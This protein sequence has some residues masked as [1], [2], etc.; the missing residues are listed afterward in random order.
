MRKS[1]GLIRM[2]LVTSNVRNVVFIDDVSPS[3]EAVAYYCL[4]RLVHR[5]CVY[6]MGYVV[7]RMLQCRANWYHPCL[8]CWLHQQKV[9]HRHMSE[10]LLRRDLS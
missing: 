4:C 3:S 2:C 8:H 7:S 10:V 5:A 1:I 6:K 9:S